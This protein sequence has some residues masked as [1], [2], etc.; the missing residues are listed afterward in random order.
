MNSD[1]SLE[2]KVT[3]SLHFWTLPLPQLNID[4][5]FCVV[6]ILHALNCSWNYELPAPE[7]I[8]ANLCGFFSPIQEEVRGFFSFY[9]RSLGAPEFSNTWG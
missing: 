7:I 9:G 1:Q 5:V 3:S 4:T 6:P 8:P 2:V